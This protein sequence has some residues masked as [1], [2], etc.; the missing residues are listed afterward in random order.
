MSSTTATPARKDFCAGPEGP[1][2]APRG[3]SSKAA[4]RGIERAPTPDAGY[5]AAQAFAREHGIQMP[6]RDA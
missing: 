2:K 1:V 6:M 5:E 3:T 4:A